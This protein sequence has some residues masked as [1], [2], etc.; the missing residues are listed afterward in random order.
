MTWLEKELRTKVVEMDA[1]LDMMSEQIKG[2]Q[3]QSPVETKET[4]E[5]G[6][7]APR[8]APRDAP[9]LLDIA[10]VESLRRSM[11]MS[12]DSN[13]LGNHSHSGLG[14]RGPPLPEGWPSRSSNVDGSAGLRRVDA[15]GE[16]RSVLQR[17]RSA[18]S[19]SSGFWIAGDTSPFQPRRRWR[20]MQRLWHFLEEPDSSPW[21][22][23]YARLTPIIIMASVVMSFIQNLKPAPLHSVA[24]G[25]FETTFDALSSLEVAARYAVAPSAAIFA[26]NRFN[27]LD[28]T[29][30][31]S[32]LLRASVGFILEDS[33]DGNVRA[34]LLLVV[35][36][37]RLL[38]TLRHFE[39]FHLLTSAFKLTAEALPV[40]LFVLVLEVMFFSS[41]IFYFEPIVDSFPTAIWLT[42]VTMST[43]GYGDIVP[44]STQGHIIV[45]AL[46]VSSAL[47]MAIPLGIVGSTFSKVWDDR[48]RLLL[49]RRTKDR[50]VQGGYDP[51]D[52]PE[53]FK[54]FGA[55][56]TGVLSLKDFRRM[57]IQMKIGMSEERICE[58]FKS[59]DDDGNGT[60][61]DQEFMRALFPGAFAEIY[62][63]SSNGPAIEM[64]KSLERGWK[65]L[66]T[67]TFEMPSFNLQQQGLRM[68]AS[69]GSM[70]SMSVI[71][72]LPNLSPRSLTTA[73]LGSRKRRPSQP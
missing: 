6:S 36:L 59:F 52:I 55:E 46:I 42:I 56:Q 30:I 22:T 33:D 45:S 38:R 50:I 20:C 73:T 35:P 14:T 2:L 19:A 70:R 34:I 44:V 12:Q 15:L 62:G 40:L 9:S 24:V 54:L 16:L 5:S 4:K 57:L 31:C 72:N 26:S 71:Q 17:G 29:A 3:L 27:L 51:R 11:R 60:L 25:V 69:F 65:K 47:Y 67:G 48:D 18:E 43:V 39:T 32:L 21:A 37:L 53:L 1:K 8:D 41:L 10:F 7:D 13:T 68:Q 49:M 63:E 66:R 28:L 61:D 64:F 23:C 58:L